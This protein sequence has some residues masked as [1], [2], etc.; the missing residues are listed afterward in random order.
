MPIVAVAATLEPVMAQKMPAESIVATTRG[1]G[2]RLNQ[3]STSSKIRWA[4]ADSP[5]NIPPR[6]KSGMAVR[7]QEFT[8]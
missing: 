7:G 6:T 4:A 3:I 8:A 2:T 1:D 5:I